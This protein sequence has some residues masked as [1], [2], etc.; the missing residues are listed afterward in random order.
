MIHGHIT[1][2]DHVHISAATLAL[3]SIFEPGQYTG[4]FPIAKHSDWGKSAV[5]VRNLNTMREKIRFLEKSVKQLTKRYDEY[6][7]SNTRYQPD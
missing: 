7:K 3:C 6:S 5:L 2:V 4:F 1:I